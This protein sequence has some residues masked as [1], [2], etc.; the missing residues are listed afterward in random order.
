MPYR[1]SVSLV[2]DPQAPL[3]DLGSPQQYLILCCHIDL[4]VRTRTIDRGLWDT[5]AQLGS[6]QLNK[7]VLTFDLYL[8]SATAGICTEKI[9]K[10]DKR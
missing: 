2:S 3:G 1:Q 4:P 6:P 10:T 7:Y 5:S 9:I 8:Y